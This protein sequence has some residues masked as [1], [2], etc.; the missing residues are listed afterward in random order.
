ML[1][2]N[3]DARL[4]SLDFT[5]ESSYGTVKSAWTVNGATARWTVTIP[6]NARGRLPLTPKRA[7]DFTIG[8][9]PLAHNKTL[10]AT[11]FGSESGY[12][13]PAGTYTFEVKLSAPVTDAETND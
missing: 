11:T 8:G 13:I 6:A 12:E 7:A 4:G 10:K 3:F 5:Y 9:Q 2:P 1:R